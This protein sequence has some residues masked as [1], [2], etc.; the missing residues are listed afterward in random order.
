MFR[1]PLLTSSIIAAIAALPAYGSSPHFVFISEYIEG[2]S[3]NKSI[4]L[5]NPTES[6]I[7]LDNYSLAKSVNGGGTW[8][9]VLSLNGYSIA[10]GDVLVISHTDANAAIQSETDLTDT[11]VISFNGDDPV[12]LLDSNGDVVDV[13]GVMG[14][15]N[16]GKDVTLVRL[17]EYFTP[18][19][20]Y[21]ASQW[22][23]LGKDISNDLGKLGAATAPT[24]FNCLD[25][26]LEPVF[27]DIQTL[28]GDGFSSPYVDGY[29]YESSQEFYVKGVV[30]AVTSGLTK[31]FYLHALVDDNDPNT[32]EGLFVST[33][34]NVSELSPGDV[35]CAYGKVQEYYDLTQLK[36]DDDKWVTL[37]RQEAPQ[38]IAISVLD[39]D[40][41]FEQTL[42][43]YE[44]MLV[45]LDQ[46][47][48]MRVSRTFGFDYAAYRNNMVVA[49]ER[50]NMQPNQLHPAGSLEANLVQAENDDRRLFI[51]S[52]TKAPNGVIPYYP[53]FGLYDDDGDGSADDY[54][55]IDDTLTG[56]Q[57]VI[58]YSYNDYRLIVTN[59]LSKDN[60]V[61]NQPRLDEPD[62]AAGDLR[63]ATFNVLNYFNSPFGGND[64]QF[65][66][67]RGAYSDDEFA[68]QQHKIVQALKGLDGDI[69]GLMEIENNGF[70]EGSAIE[71]LVTELNAIIDDEDNHY[72]YVAVDSNLNDEFDALDSVGT[73][74]IAVG[75]IYKPSAVK[76]LETDVIVMPRQDAPAVIIDG[77]EVESGK[78]Y[79]R[80]ALAPTFQVLGGKK[81][82]TVAVNHFKS[83][84]SS[85]WEDVAPVE[86]GG[87]ASQDPDKQ[88]SCEAFRVAAAVALGEALKGGG[89][90]KVIL[91]DLNS[92]AKEDPMLILTDY[93]MGQY[94]KEI[95]AAR[96]T[97]IGDEPQFGDEGAVIDH[98]YGYINAVEMM[99]PES[100]S[101]SYNDEVGALD[102]ILV[103]KSLKNRVVDAAE[104]HINGAE[105]SLFAYSGQYTGD[106]PK[107]S[108][109]YRSSD[110]DPAVVE[111][112]IYKRGASMGWGVIFGLIAL[113][114]LRRRNLA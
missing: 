62:V 90:Y 81:R 100:W 107:Y 44:G 112:Q 108:D 88:G 109:I 40:Q 64:N 78:N 39:T 18:S 59:T 38:A 42:E 24:A 67:N 76:L 60:F 56:A 106:L 73:D 80:D 54:I 75:V 77:E 92:Y 82:I 79:Q 71:Q 95:R 20:T 2:G 93:T 17:S 36:I 7:T 41:S 94:G 53:D 13:V 111:L 69:V 16:F 70:G 61:H 46:T 103:S 102:H 35:V 28:Q 51:E 57:G 89:S 19:S 49:H 105:S 45:E 52:D 27:T 25:N 74:A 55:R 12:A 5:A 3:F 98:H 4:E 11:S 48:D 26:D 22:L 33:Q 30:S 15:I 14:D 110:H 32:S 47:L 29:P 31:G 85:C 9:N 113:I 114:G 37:D 83:K 87:Q 68:L 97:Y 66:S 34:A 58:T 6:D 50:V 65:G 104:W 21:D 91:G 1:K 23:Q 72:E 96:N 63:I 101:Y 99:Q 10:A 84:G 43:R 86:E 8:D